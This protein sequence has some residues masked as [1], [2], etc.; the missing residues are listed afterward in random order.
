MPETE[1]R[2]SMLRGFRKGVLTLWG[3]SDNAER[4]NDVVV[5]GVATFLNFEEIILLLIIEYGF[6]SRAVVS[7][8]ILM[9]RR[10]DVLELNSIMLLQV[11][12]HL[13]GGE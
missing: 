13:E 2:V 9:T 4:S 1:G 6:A 12:Y 3:E 5:P 10:V 11:R 7:W 8:T